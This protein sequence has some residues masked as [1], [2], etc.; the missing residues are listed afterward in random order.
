MKQQILYLSREDVEK[1]NVEMKEI[2]DCLDKMFFLK[3]NNKTEMPPKP[4]IHT[5]KDSFI[6]AM[7]AYIPDMNAA[8]MKW[9][10]GY[11]DNYKHGLPYISGLIILN[12][13][14]TGVP[15]SVMDCTWITAQRTGAATAL[16]ARYL[17][18]KDSQTVGILGCGVQGISNLEALFEVQKDIKNVIIY[19]ILPEK[20]D[21]YIYKMTHIKSGIVYIKAK[22]P[23]EA[24]C[25][26]DI[27]VT[28]GPIL[29]NPKQVIEPEWFKE[30]AFASPVDFDSYWKPEAMHLCDK[31]Y[32]DDTQQLMY[33]KSAG[34]F[35]NIP[36]VYADLG[37]LV[38]GKK[39]ARTTDK[40]RIIS[41]NLGIALEDMAVS[42]V[43]YNKAK[44]NNLGLYL[45][46]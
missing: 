14:E 43:I 23:K 12:D 5:R 32:T 27:I 44:E 4:G 35:Q 36:E 9:V 2:I 45:E 25:D 1:T 30:G 41:A 19:D 37:E 6:H 22:D 40:E 33:Y 13:P 39:S 20:M 11:P 17:A 28:S 46:L 10:S 26:S 21:Q 29:K 15:Y 3:G 31:F 16:A 42:V 8:G 24:V 18:R 7:P 38:S 34:Y